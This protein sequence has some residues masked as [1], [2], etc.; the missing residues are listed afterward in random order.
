MYI[1]ETNETQYNHSCYFEKMVK[2][3]LEEAIK[4]CVVMKIPVFITAAVANENGET[5]YVNLGNMTGSTGI[6]LNDDQ[7]KQHL[8]VACGLK[9]E[10]VVKQIDIDGYIKKS[11]DPTDTDT[12]VIAQEYN[13]FLKTEKKRGRRPGDH[14]GTVRRKGRPR[15]Q[16]QTE[17]TANHP[18]DKEIDF[19]D[20]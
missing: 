15:K 4:R 13:V 5:T 2:P 1:G 18:F 12:E 10:P 9:T 17:D 14:E 6:E 8:L 19:E 20:N 7:F 16:K 3:H 11:D